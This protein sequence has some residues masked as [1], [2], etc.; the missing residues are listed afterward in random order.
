[1]ELHQIKLYGKTIDLEVGDLFWQNSPS[2][3]IHYQPKG[4]NV[5]LIPQGTDRWYRNNYVSCQKYEKE[6]RLAENLELIQGRKDGFMNEWTVKYVYK[7]DRDEFDDLILM[8]INASEFKV[9]E[10]PIERITDKLIF[11]KRSLPITYLSRIEKIHLLTPMFHWG[12]MYGICM[13]DD[14]QKLEQILFERF[15]IHLQDTMINLQ[16]SLQTERLK[17]AAF[18]KLRE[19]F[20]YQM[21]KSKRTKVWKIKSN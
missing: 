7:Q 1:M 8:E 15:A 19:Q 12:R 5:R 16:D 18:Q 13:A 2:G 4:A 14:Y 11:L 10:C 3:P 20:G 9:T 17:S 6:I 21:T